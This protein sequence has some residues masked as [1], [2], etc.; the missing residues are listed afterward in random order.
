MQK[1]ITIEKMILADLREFLKEKEIDSDAYDWDVVEEHPT[2]NVVGES[3]FIL[4]NSICSG[5]FVQEEVA[6]LS[7]PKY[8][9]KLLEYV[10][11]KYEKTWWLSYWGK[12]Q[13]LERIISV[14]KGLI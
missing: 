4:N 10:I 6:S 13:A 5:N 11:R 2:I 9:E 7:D 14:R 12:N 3:Y 1:E 8:K